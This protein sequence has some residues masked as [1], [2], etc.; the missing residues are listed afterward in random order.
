MN[1][2][3]YEELILESIDGQIDEAGRRS[4]DAHLK[5]CPRCQ[6]FWKE[7]RALDVRLASGLRRP[8]LSPDFKADMLRRIDA[9]S[10]PATGAL[11]LEG[12][13]RV[14]GFWADLRIYIP[15]ILDLAGYVFVGVIMGVVLKSAW[16]HAPLPHTYRF[17]PRIP[18]NAALM[19]AWVTGAFCLF[20]GLWISL[21]TT[22]KW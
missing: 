2:S 4:L 19:M 3:N 15:E 9:D 12:P 5:T 20:G 16:V 7:H 21:K 14:P 22:L 18:E 8:A 17:L 6:A 13:L 11:R 1:C 10:A